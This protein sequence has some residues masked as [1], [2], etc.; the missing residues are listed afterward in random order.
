MLVF[1]FAGP[2]LATGLVFGCL[3]L[4]AAQVQAQ[5]PARYVPPAGNP[6][7]RELNYFRRDVGLLDQ[8]NAFVFPQLQMNNQL[9]QLAAQQQ[10]NFR[11]AQRQINELKDVRSSTA[12]PTGTGATFMNYGHYYNLQQ[13]RVAAPR[14][15]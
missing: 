3:V 2:R 7:P 15:R 1:R 10:S 14:T 12:A 11:S 5:G 13:R 6:L 9:Q 8:Y 4:A